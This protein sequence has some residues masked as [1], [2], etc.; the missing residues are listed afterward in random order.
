MQSI[1]ED[2]TTDLSRLQGSIVVGRADGMVA[3]G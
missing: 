2:V 1:T 3:K